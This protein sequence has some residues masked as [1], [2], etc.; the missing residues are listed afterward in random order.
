[1]S[2]ED[3]LSLWEDD[4]PLKKE[5]VAYVEAVTD[6]SSADFIPVEDRVATFDFDGT[7]FCETDPQLL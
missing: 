4:A 1:V 5:L 3:P 6:E 7:L 2:D